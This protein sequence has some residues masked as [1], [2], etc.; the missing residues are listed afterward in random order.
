MIEAHPKTLGWKTRARIGT[1]IKWY[2][3]VGDLVR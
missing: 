2:N 1:R 3:E